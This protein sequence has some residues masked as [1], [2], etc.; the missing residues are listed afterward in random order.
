MNSVI[1]IHQKLNIIEIKYDK[2]YNQQSNI[3]EYDHKNILCYNCIIN[4]NYLK[5]EA[6]ENSYVEGID[7]NSLSNNKKTAYYR[8]VGALRE[9]LYKTNAL[10]KSEGY[11]KIYEG[12]TPRTFNAGAN[13]VNLQTDRLER[14]LG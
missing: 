1:F 3:Y 10:S 5:D 7:L 13:T 8:A 2:I 11:D 6:D 12:S 9:G 14:T 4:K